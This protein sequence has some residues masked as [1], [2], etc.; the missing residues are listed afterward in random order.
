MPKAKRTKLTPPEVAARYGISPDKVLAWIRAGELR[1]V[2]IATRPTGKP[3]WLIDEA[4]L[5]AFETRRTAQVVP[6]V[7]PRRRCGDT[8]VIAYF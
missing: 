4:D 6:V 3:R 5:A 7:T 2:N 1:A 8:D